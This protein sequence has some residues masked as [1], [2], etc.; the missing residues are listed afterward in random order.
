[1]WIS[2]GFNRRGRGLN[3]ENR[4][5]QRSVTHQTRC[6]FQLGN[7]KKGRSYEIVKERNGKRTIKIINSLAWGYQL[8]L[9]GARRLESFEE[10]GIPRCR[11]TLPDGRIRN[12]DCDNIILVDQDTIDAKRKKLQSRQWRT[13]AS[14]LSEQ[15]CI[16]VEVEGLGNLENAICRL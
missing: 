13:S 16:S 7:K 14:I 4:F 8:I 5:L 9:V 6:W 10:M 2:R 3:R 15:G 12:T 11:K 1:M